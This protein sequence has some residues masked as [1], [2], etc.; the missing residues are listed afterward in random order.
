MKRM[1][2][3]C[4]AAAVLCCIGLL[5]GNAI[6]AQAAGKDYR[7]QAKAI[8]KTMTWKEK[9]AQM[10]MVAVPKSQAD[11]VQKNYQFGGYV[12]FRDDFSG[13]TPDQAQKLIQSIQ[14]ASKVKTLISVDEEGGT[15]TRV[16]GLARYRSRK[17]A[18]PQEVWRKGGW[19]G[20]REDTRQKADFLKKLGINTNLAPV[21]DV[22]YRQSDFI[23]RRSFSTNADMTAKYIKTV[24]K[25]M[26]GKDLVSTLKHFPGYG[27]NGDTH[28]LVIRDTRS[29]SAF[30]KRDLKPFAAGIEAGC[31]MIMVSHNVVNC[32]D[33]S[34][35]ASLSKKVHDYLRETMGFEGVIITDDICMDGAA[36]FV[37]GSEKAAVKAVQAGSDMVCA[38][39]YRTQYDAVV[40]AFLR[41]GISR[42]QIN[43]SVERILV[44]KLRRGIIKS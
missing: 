4:R 9:I 31:D 30:E 21:A 11:Q 17:F 43:A 15:V 33:R 16:S 26:D 7:K 1:H 8:M 39:S 3:F 44:M 18:S 34:M 2:I 24:V 29:R 36:S 19:S 28:T 32:F 6:P 14:K 27:G 20:I 23:Y 35:P 38:T 41:G 5:L 10:F 40:K 13:R 42:A 22:P 12:F 37:G 25:E